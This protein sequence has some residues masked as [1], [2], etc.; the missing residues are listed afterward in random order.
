MDKMLTSVINSIPL[1]RAIYPYDCMIAVSDL[2]EFIFYSPGTKM[3]HTNPVGKAL[4][5]GDGL[6]E[7]IQQRNAV[8]SIVPKDIW[9]FM[10]KSKSSPIIN[11]HGQVVGALGLG[12]SLDIQE[13][14]HNAAETIASSSE[15]V[16]AFSEELTANAAKLHEKLGNLQATSDKAIKGL[17][18]SNQ[19]LSFITEIATSTNLLGLNASIEAARAGESGKGFTVVAQEIRKLSSNS[20]SS[21]KE[22]RD[23]LS[24][25]R[26]EFINIGKKINEADTLS[27]QQE[28]STQD[29]TK[30]VESLALLAETIQGI[31]YEV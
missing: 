6:T 3:K 30:S 31:S 5:R 29:I 18:K 10:F 21:V 8:S 15:E 14:L 11:E 20:S 27:A 19:I 17:D 2:N 23:T 28:E 25:I 24:R 12:H 9:G 16:I 22:I 7:A 1:I 13:M 4:S 26:D